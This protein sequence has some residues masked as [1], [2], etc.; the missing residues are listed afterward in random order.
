MVLL[1]KHSVC[2]SKTMY[3]LC[4]FGIWLQN[5]NSESNLIEPLN[6]HN[7]PLLD[8]KPEIFALKS[9]CKRAA[10]SSRDR[11][12]KLFKHVVRNDFAAAFISHKI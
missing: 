3:S 9:E 7:H 1:V 6:S 8:Y 11:L 4:L 10:R 12:S 5:L 2:F